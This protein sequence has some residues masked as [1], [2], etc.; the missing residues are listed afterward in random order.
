MKRWT[1]AFAGTIV[2]AL[3]AA[4]VTAQAPG[5]RDGEEGQRGRQGRR[6]GR[7]PDEAPPVFHTDVPQHPLDIILA[8][9]T[10]DSVTLSVLAYRN[11]EGH[12][13]YGTQKGV[14]SSQTGSARFTNGQPVE[15]VIDGLRPN[16]Q[17][18]YQL[19]Y[20]EPGRDAF[21]ESNEHSFHTQ[22]PPGATFVF[23]VQ[24]DSH[25]DENTDPEVYARTLANAL[26][27]KPD[28]HIDLGD[29]FMTDKYGP[30]YKDALKQYLAQR[31]Y[32]GLLCHSAPLFFVLGNHDGETG[33]RRNG[34]AENVSVWSNRTRKLYYPNPVADGFYTGNT[35]HEEF[36][37][38]LQDYYAWEWGDALFVVLGPFWYTSSRSRQD[39]DYWDRTLGEEQYRWLKRTLEES[40]AAFKFVFIHHLVGGL[41][42][43]GRG[44]IEAAK[45][46]EW[47]GHNK[48]GR[49]AFDEKRPGWGAPIHQL[50]ADNGVAAVFHGHDHIFVKQDLDGIV[51]QLLPQPAHQRYGSTRN[52]EPYG[53]VHGD[54]LAGSGHLRVTVSAEKATVDYIVSYLPE[55]EDAGRKNG[56]IAYSYSI[57]ADPGRGG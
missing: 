37:G 23:T 51:Y 48:D 35:R 49:Y 57:N 55:D 33:W 45:Y 47:G 8:R 20:R 52:A 22:R 25:L 56:A 1:I 14:Y 39:D 7:A 38:L 9:P 54:V 53:Y 19:R 6:R 26:A 4:A 18:Y 10:G 34:G 46:F 21:S 36:V 42:R 2:V 13:A 24:A 41:D 12:F 15:V 43:N 27:N 31:Y 5:G 28:F 17:Y 11:M 30:N 16:T 32:F 50:L 29:T 40:K 3:L 44:G